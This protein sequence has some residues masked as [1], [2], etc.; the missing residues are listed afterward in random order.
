MQFFCQVVGVVC[1]LIAGQALGH[2]QASDGQYAFQLNTSSKQEKLSEKCPPN[3]ALPV[4]RVAIIGAG[5]SGSSAAYFLGK[6]REQLQEY[7]VPGCD[8]E[9]TPE[10]LHVTVYERDSRIGGRI[11]A[12]HPLN[13]SHFPPIDV[14][15][16]IFANVNHNMRHAARK[17]GLEPAPRDAKLQS[18]MGLWDGS[19]FVIDDFDGS[20]WSQLKLYW[21]YG[22]SPTKALTLYVSS[23]TQGQQ[24]HKCI[25]AHLLSP[26]LARPKA[27]EFVPLAHRDRHRRG[28]P[29]QGIHHRVCQ[30]L[31]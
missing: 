1:L 25:P 22:K 14:G 10:D 16:S 13:D 2:P 23:L 26:F 15:A 29:A 11:M 5:A 3:N 24:G 7:G 17:F 9:M 28:S 21:R 4:L 31:F 8:S 27:Q 6:A 19:Q 20:R 30:G 12:V 18:P